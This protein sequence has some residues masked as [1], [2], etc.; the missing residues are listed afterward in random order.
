MGG[1]RS[2]DPKLRPLSWGTVSAKTAGRGEGTQRGEIAGLEFEAERERGA[3]GS[4]RFWVF[5]LNGVGDQPWTTS[6]PVEVSFIRPP[7]GNGHATI[8]ARKIKRLDRR[9]GIYH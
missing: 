1:I 2:A 5:A 8:E 7:R 4:P 6:L 9:E 3:A